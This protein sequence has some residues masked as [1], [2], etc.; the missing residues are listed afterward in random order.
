[1]TAVDIQYGGF[2]RRLAA[3]VLDLL[4]LFLPLAALEY[5]GADRDRLFSAYFL[6]PSTLVGLYY[7]VFLVRRFGGTPGKLLLQLRI[8]KASGDTA[9]YRESLLRYAP[10]L[11]LGLLLSLSLIPPLLRMTDAEYH[12]LS[13]LERSSRLWELAPAWTQ[14][15]QIAQQ[16][17]IFS[18]IVV[19]LTNDKR[20]ALHDFLAGTVVAYEPRA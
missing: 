14:P 16:V 18:E 9:G 17:W 1:M 12:G 10:E 20:R 19:L 7:H 6:V 2:W 4:I 8:R 13:F 15:L 11:A 3:L 5:W